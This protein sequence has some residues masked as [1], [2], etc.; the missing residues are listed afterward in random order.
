[1]SQLDFVIPT[2]LDDLC[3]YGTDRYT[4]STD[5]SE[6]EV[7]QQAPGLYEKLL[8]NDCGFILEEFDVFFGVIK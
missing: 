7:T 5:F 2:K 4:V 3:T 6:E 1:M 8:Q